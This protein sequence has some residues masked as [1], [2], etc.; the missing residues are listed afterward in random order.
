MKL[1]SSISKILTNKYFLYFIVFL[2]LTNIL[3]YMMM[4]K[5]NAVFLFILIGFIISRFSKNMTVVLLVPLI[6]INFLMSGTMIQEGLD[7]MDTTTKE[8][9]DV[10]VTVTDGS[11]NVVKETDIDIEN[12]KNKIKEIQ[13]KKTEVKTNI[14]EKADEKKIPENFEVG[15][16]GRKGASRIDYGTTI[17]NAYDDLNKIIGGDG[18]KKL[19]NDT[20]KLMKQQMQLAEAMNNMGPLLQNAKDMLKGFDMSQLGNV[21]E[22]VQSMQK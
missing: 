2:S 14:Q 20:Q 13:D 5:F 3:G 6:L 12:A 4:R 7:N 16:K 22:L 15:S 18:I 1:S 11:G 10:K 21:T 9:K 17:E 8:R 19:T